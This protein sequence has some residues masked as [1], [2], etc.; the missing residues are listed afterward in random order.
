MKCD[1]KC[2]FHLIMATTCG[3]YQIN[4]RYKAKTKLTANL[5]KLGIEHNFWDTPVQKYGK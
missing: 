1:Y 4:G 3:N 2:N 5:S